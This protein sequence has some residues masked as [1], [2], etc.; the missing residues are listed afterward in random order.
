MQLVVASI[1]GIGLA[2]LCIRSFDNGVRPTLIAIAEAKVKNAVTVIINAAVDETIA[3]QAIAYDDIISLQTDQSGRITALTSNSAEMNRLRGH[4]VDAII[5]KV[6]ILDTGDLGVPLG[7]LTGFAA[8][9]DRG[10]TLPVQVLS[11]ASA[12]AVFRNQFSAAGI[13]QTYHQVMLDVTV[14]IKLL[15]PGGTVETSVLSQ[16]NVA[17]TVIVGQVPDAYLQFEQQH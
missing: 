1:L 17:E 9:S 4:I 10:P 11:V 5:C 6:G 15:V 16:I 7:N 2:L 14:N 13:N 3:A 12:D 8:L